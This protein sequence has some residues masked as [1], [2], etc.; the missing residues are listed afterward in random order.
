MENNAGISEAAKRLRELYSAR[1][2]N[3]GVGVGE[4]DR[5]LASVDPLIQMCRL[6]DVR[7]DAKT[8]ADFYPDAEETPF[9]WPQFKTLVRNSLQNYRW[10]PDAVTDAEVATWVSP[11]GL[12]AWCAVLPPVNGGREVTESMV[13][14]A[15]SDRKITDGLREDAISSLLRSTGYMALTLVAKGQAPCTG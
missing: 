15:L 12:E 2:P 8:E 3:I 14:H 7:P 4:E 6:A 9:C 13:L 10:D 1:K 5:S 11:D